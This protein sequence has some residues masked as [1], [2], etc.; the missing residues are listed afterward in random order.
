[1]DEGGQQRL[2]DLPK[3]HHAQPVAKGIENAHIWHLVPV[4][5][6]GKSAPSRLLGEQD[7]Q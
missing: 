3:A 4:P 6:T 7:D 1:L 5:Q 2:I